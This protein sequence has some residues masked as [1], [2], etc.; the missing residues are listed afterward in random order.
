MADNVII[1]ELLCFLKSHFRNIRLASILTVISSYFSEDEIC[2]AKLILH[3]LCVK[4]LGEDN[5]P[6]LIIRKGENKRKTDSEDVGNFLKLLDEHKIE[7]PFRSAVNDQQV[8]SAEFRRPSATNSAKPSYAQSLRVNISPLSNSRQ[9]LTTESRRV[10]PMVGTKQVESSGQ[11]KLKASSEPRG[12]HIYIGNLDLLAQSSDV[13]DYLK[14]ANIKVLSCE[15]L[16]SSRISDDYV[17]R[18]ASAHVVIDVT[19]KDL[20]QLLGKQALLFARGDFHVK[21]VLMVEIRIVG[22]YLCNEFIP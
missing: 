9:Q 13:E 2:K 7:L 22:N 20:I 8:G 1:S 4:Y 19:D 6:R 14:D 18:A 12:F 21:I 10:K 11:R 16:R 17:P 15:L 5:V 3:E